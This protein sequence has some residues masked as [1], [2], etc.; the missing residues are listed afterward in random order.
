MKKNHNEKKIIIK[1]SKYIFYFNSIFIKKI[2]K[3]Y[4]HYYW[5]TVILLDNFFKYNLNNFISRKLY[6][7]KQLIKIN[8][9]LI[10]RL[11]YYFFRFI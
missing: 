5:K 7:K 1:K 10:I 6:L 9:G 11:F 4:S 2:L 3:K 8:N